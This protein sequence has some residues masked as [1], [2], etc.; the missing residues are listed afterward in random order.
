[1]LV[2]IHSLLLA[3]ALTY[4]TVGVASWYESGRLTASGERYDIH[5]YTAAH[6]TLPLQSYARVTR[7]SNGRSVI[8]RI[9]DRGPYFPGRI[10]DLS[11]SA[12]DRLGMVDA[13]LAVVLVESVAGRGSPAGDVRVDERLNNH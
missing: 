12:A 10:I 2:S 5:A 6:R 1:M 11:K 9:N 3:A 13:G 7:L 8:V 4:S